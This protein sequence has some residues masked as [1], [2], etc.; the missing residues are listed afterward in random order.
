[1]ENCRKSAQAFRQSVSARY[2]VPQF[3][4]IREI[5][6]QKL[7]E[8]EEI[9]LL[10]QTEDSDLRR[11]PW[12]LFFERFLESYRQAEVALSLPEYERS[13]KPAPVRERVRILAVLGNS[14]GINIEE[15][16]QLLE[17]L[18]DAETVF[19]ASPAR[20][21]LDAQLWDDRGW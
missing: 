20:R 15:E 9:R 10:V 12:N 16:R 11:L 18:P 3:A 14:A 4:P 6:L 8:S 21:E 5:L 7:H 19:L 1:M 13:E 17:T 2:G